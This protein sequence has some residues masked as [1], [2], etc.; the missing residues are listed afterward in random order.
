MD[1]AITVLQEKFNDLD[2]KYQHLKHMFEGYREYVL[3]EILRYNDDKEIE[4]AIDDERYSPGSARRISYNEGWDLGMLAF[5]SLLEDVNVDPLKLVGDI[6]H[7]K[8]EI[9]L[10]TLIE[11]IQMM[12]D[13]VE[14]ELGFNKGKRIAFLE[15]INFLK[16]LENEK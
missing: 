2:N 10:D 13:K 3:I 8:P 6:K 1:D 15:V 12:Q 11:T 5:K 16:T 14:P 9:N 7:I 4:D